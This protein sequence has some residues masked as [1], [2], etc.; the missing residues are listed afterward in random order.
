M[1]IAF[2][3]EYKK[4]RHKYNLSHLRT[5]YTGGSMMPEYIM[6][7]LINEMGIKEMNTVY[8]Q[9]ETST[10]VFHSKLG[11]SVSKRCKTV[12]RPAPN[13]ETKIVDPITR[14][15]LPWG[16][17]GEVC[18]RGY[19]VMKG[20]WGDEKKTK[21]LIDTDGWLHSGDLG[22]FDEDG[23]LVLVGRSKDMIIR[24]GENIYPIEIEEFMITHPSIL[25][26]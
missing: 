25:D 5:G 7:R 4:N 12:G 20:Y 11:D 26:V 15:I 8:G 18:S 21:E 17:I 22:K 10:V 2:L 19:F 9:T 24:G 1:F 3:D 23:H 13:V 16:E 6:D 14:Q